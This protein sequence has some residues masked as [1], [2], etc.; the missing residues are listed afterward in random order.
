[1]GETPKIP[2]FL[3]LSLSNK[4]LVL[5]L[6]ANPGM[7]YILRQQKLSLSFSVCTERKRPRPARA[8]D[9]VDATRAKY[10][11]GRHNG[12]RVCTVEMFMN[13]FLYYFLV[14]QR[15]LAVES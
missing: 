4:N 12:A 14:K 10:V 13:G 7:Y 3:T 11:P 15:D 6:A 8:S 5:Q 9:N 2:S 1:M